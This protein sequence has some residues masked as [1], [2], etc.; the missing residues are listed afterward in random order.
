[1]NI[2][3]FGATS[4]IAKDLIVSLAMYTNYECILFARDP[5]PVYN[6]L[7]SIEMEK[8][9][10]VS[11][12]S[13][14]EVNDSYD[15]IINFIGI[16]DPGRANKA[17]NAIF[18]ITYKYDMMVLK[19]LKFQPE[20]K[21]LFLS[22]GA[23]YGG[24]FE[25]PVTDKTLA[26]I[27][28]NNMSKTDWYAMAKIYAE[29]RHRALPEYAII[30]IRVFNYFSHTQYMGANFFITELV[31]ALQRNKIFR[32]SKENIVRDFITPSD[33]FNL[34]Q[35]I[36]KAKSK[37]MPVD[38]YTRKSVKKF[39]LLSE[40]ER[41][42]HFRYAFPDSLEITNATGHK[43]NYYSVNHAAR[44]FGYDPEKTSM[45]GVIEEIKKYMMKLKSA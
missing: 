12:Y 9:Y 33:F 35:A 2:A 5:V 43:I 40:I 31:H 11:H 3:I 26:K 8:A 25:K 10:K 18:D 27:D 19:Y 32:T 37:N 16:G 23:V 17:G 29:A 14:F 42:F 39:D 22:S 1:V 20:C 41:N 6:W 4:Q 28:V 38:C 7:N 24:S 15:V 21:Y 45:D 30:D 13:Y 44:Q 34:I 36:M